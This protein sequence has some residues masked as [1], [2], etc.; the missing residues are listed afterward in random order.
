MGAA[1]DSA[2]DTAASVGGSEDWLFDDFAPDAEVRLRRGLVARYGVE[3]GVEACAE[4]MA[5]ALPPDRRRLAHL[6]LRQTPTANKRDE[7]RRAVGDGP[8]RCGSPPLLPLRCSRF[9][10]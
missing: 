6:P 8:H 1:L 10:A 5:Y 9:R 2:P 4:A 7:S 3:L